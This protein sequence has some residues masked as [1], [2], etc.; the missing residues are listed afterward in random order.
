[1]CR[2]LRYLCV[3]CRLSIDKA[4]QA[5][6]VTITHGYLVGGGVLSR[7]WCSSKSSALFCYE[8]KV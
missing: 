2:I 5:S 7:P 1:M 8:D 4:R 6:C 3:G